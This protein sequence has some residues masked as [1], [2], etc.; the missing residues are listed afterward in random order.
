MRQS[1]LFS[2]LES[3]AYNI[4]RKNKNLKL[5]EFGKT[6]HKFNDTYQENKHVSLFVTGNRSKH[7]WIFPNKKSDFFYLK[8]VVLAILTRLGIDKVKTTPTKLDVFS[9]G[10]TLSLGKIKLVDLGVVNNKILKE[11]GIKQEVL[12]ADVNW[13]NVLQLLGK[14]KVK[15]AD[16]PKFPTVK[17]DLALLIDKKVSFKEIYNLAFQA[18]KNLLKN[19][20]L[21]DVYEGDNLPEGKKSYAVSF[22]LQ[23]VNKTLNEKQIEKIMQKLKATFEKNLNAVLR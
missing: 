16:L 7:S 2:G 14:K 3:V 5:Y 9:E 15:I 10:I 8:G 1:L 12:F 18:E 4:N 11:F 22:I 20:D 13:Q 17:R 21:F 6:Y 19:V 23:D